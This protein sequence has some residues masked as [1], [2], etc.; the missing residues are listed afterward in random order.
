M[1]NKTFTLVGGFNLVKFYFARL[2]E[3]PTNHKFVLTQ[4]FKQFI[5]HHL[6]LALATV[7]VVLV[8][9]GSLRA[10]NNIAI[11]PTGANA[12]PSALLDVSSTTGG[13]LTPR[14]TEAERLA[15]AAPVNGLVLF[16]TDGDQGF[17]YWDGGAAIP[18]WRKMPRFLGATIE[19]GPAPSTIVHGSG[20]S[21][22]R[23]VT[24]TDQI[25]FNQQLGA[26]PNVMLSSTLAFGEAPD[27]TGYCEM[28]FTS[29]SCHHIDDLQVWSGATV[30]TGTLLIDNLNSDCNNEPGRTI[31]YPFGAPV[32]AEPTAD[33]CLNNTNL[34]SIGMRGNSPSGAQPLSC[35]EHE[36]KIYIDWLQDGFF[37][38]ADD[39]VVNTGLVT[40]G[41]Q[42][43]GP[44]P[45]N[46][47]PIPPIGNAFN[48]TTYLRAFATLNG[49]PNA[50]ANDS[51]GEGEQYEVSVTCRT[52]P[53]YED[54]PTYCNV[55]DVTPFAYRV[56]CRR[57]G[58]ESR[59]VKNYYFQVNENQ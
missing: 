12:H 6:V 45:Y 16:Q 56:S 28:E 8:G 43:V 44:A 24:G 25:D 11:N 22:T 40:W 9:V 36:T 47:R 4:H 14:M 18:A 55:G 57:L 3:S 13:M 5:T 51:E 58:G 35:G 20:F 2:I 32:Y 46:N 19:M 33:L 15:I 29:C 10:Q 52:S 1:R 39:L 49:S 31:F 21:V 41:S 50:C 59:N 7:L 37:D 48:G 27:L 34:Y 23:L 54:V 17:W 53:V 30:G 42:P 26:V 38:A